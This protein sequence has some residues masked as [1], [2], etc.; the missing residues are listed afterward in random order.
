MT[1]ENVIALIQKHHGNLT[2]V[3]RA[4]NIA[5]ST[6]Y[7]YIDNNPEIKKVL[8]DARE[9]MVDNVE[10]VLYKKALEGNT[11]E[12]L[13]FLKTQGRSRGYNE[14]QE[15]TIENAPPKIKVIFEERPTQED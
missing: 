10:S 11:V 14:K 3:A 15:I 13:F 5:R 6:L 7:I 4:F 2:T 9:S 12:M 8:E 1:P